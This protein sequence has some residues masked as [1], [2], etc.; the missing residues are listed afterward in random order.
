MAA[1]IALPVPV[2]L[3]V[4]VTPTSAQVAAAQALPAPAA[5]A[6][7]PGQI[8][9]DDTPASNAASTLASAL[10]AATGTPLPAQN[11]GAT[12]PQLAAV[13]AAA[14]Q[15][16]PQNAAALKPIAVATNAAAP[17]PGTAPTASAVVIGPG[18]AP[19]LVPAAAPATP[20]ALPSAA[21]DL[22]AR[23]AAGAQTLASQPHV[24][25]AA[26]APGEEKVGTDTA[27]G[28]HDAPALD[29]SHDLS[30]TTVVAS[31][32]FAGKLIPA[33]A[34]VGATVTSFLASTTVAETNAA[35]GAVSANASDTSTA[36]A[37]PLAAAQPP[38]PSSTPALDGTPAASQPLPPPPV[39]EQVAIGL[40]QFATNGTDH[41]QIQLQ[42]ADLGAIQVKLNVSH[43][44][45]VEVVV[46]AARSD[47][48][49]LLQQDSSNLTQAL[50]DAG[51]QADSSSLSFNLHGGNQSNQQ[52]TTNGAAPTVA[53]AEDTSDDLGTLLPAGP[54]LRAHTG[55]VDIHV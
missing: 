33:A 51:L 11:V 29:P 26:L 16:S 3:V 49:N 52:A 30:K 8:G 54:A 38:A 53:T 13:I 35:A 42:P 27:V 6:A 43:E 21:N 55:S 2:P 15:G 48:L 46:S 18:A 17:T 32:D 10:A 39:V 37:Q 25:L 31:S 45:R 28:I 47:T 24:A 34:K 9:A 7:V 19:G 12:S 36:G 40:R 20:P 1:V 50:R 5:G 22:G 44:G 23:I 14:A 41:I 4:P